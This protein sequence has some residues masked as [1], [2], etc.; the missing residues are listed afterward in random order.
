MICSLYFERD[1]LPTRSSEQRWR[2]PLRLGLE[3]EQARGDFFGVLLGVLLR[4]RTCLWLSGI[5]DRHWYHHGP[6]YTEP[7]PQ[8]VHRRV[9]YVRRGPQV[10][11][12][13]RDGR[14]GRGGHL[15]EPLVARL[16]ALAVEDVRRGLRV[17]VGQPACDELGP[18]PPLLA[19]QVGRVGP[20]H[21]QPVAHP[22]QQTGGHATAAGAREVERLQPGTGLLELEDAVPAEG[23]ATLGQGRRRHPG[24]SCSFVRRGGLAHA[25]VRQRD[26]HAGAQERL[27]AL[28]SHGGGPRDGREQCWRGLARRGR[29]QLVDLD[30]GV[31]SSPG[32]E[33]VQGLSGRVGVVDLHQIGARSRPRSP[34]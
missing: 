17:R 25:A 31:D 21:V 11:E 6:W 3:L 28:I 16:L 26:A 12:P 2:P 33:E 9:P 20:V 34:D 29:V 13:P 15:E 27:D 24:A 5:R 19:P 30:G 4:P 10:G 7:L 1:K 18:Q 14:H 8:A 22:F 23:D 32:L